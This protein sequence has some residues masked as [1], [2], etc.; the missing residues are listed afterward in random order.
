[1]Y[2]TLNSL[3]LYALFC[4]VKLVSPLPDTTASQ[5]TRVQQVT[6]MQTY[7]YLAL[8]GFNYNTFYF[9]QKVTG[10]KLLV[11]EVMAR[12]VQR[13]R[14]HLQRGLQSTWK[15][16]R[17]TYLKHH[18]AALAFLRKNTLKQF[19]EIESEDLITD[20]GNWWLFVFFIII[21]IFEKTKAYKLHL[22]LSGKFHSVTIIVHEKIWT[23]KSSRNCSE[24]CSLSCYISR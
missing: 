22:I 19:L 12:I 23:L 15:L 17:S 18:K 21:I 6:L 14:F 7:Y 9:H 20:K 5:V 2:Y 13:L 24:F 16:E 8:I 3:T 1:M 11:Q 10:L 4:S